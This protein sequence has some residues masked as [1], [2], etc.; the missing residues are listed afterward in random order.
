MTR[1]S[2]IAKVAQGPT[3]IVRPNTAFGKRS[4]CDKNGWWPATIDARFGSILSKKSFWGNR[5]NYLEP[6]TRFVRIDVRDQIASQKN[7]HEPWYRRCRVSQRP[8]GPKINICEI[9][10]V[11]RFSTFSTAS[12]KTGKP[13]CEHMFSALPPTTDMER[14]RRYVRVVCALHARRRCPYR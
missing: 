10:D 7:N 2:Q 4:E 5:R 13:Q 12:V 14:P 1:S 11:V 3:K 8:S 9:F 6:L